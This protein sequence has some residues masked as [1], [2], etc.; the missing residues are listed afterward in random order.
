M[1]P[2]V[3]TDSI[4][5]GILTITLPEYSQEAGEKEEYAQIVISW[6]REHTDAKGIVIDLCGNRGGDVAPMMAALSPLLPDGNVLGY[7][8]ANGQINMMTLKNGTCNG[9]SGITVV[10]AEPFCHP[11]G[12]V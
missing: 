8:Y 3:R 1:L 12:T 11:E 10:T 9:G 6:L 5:N 4:H 7:K 2:I